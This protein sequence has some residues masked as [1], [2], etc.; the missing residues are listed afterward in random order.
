MAVLL[1]NVPLIMT[2]FNGVVIEEIQEAFR[3]LGY[4]TIAEIMTASDFGVP[5]FRKRAVVIGYRKD[6]GFSPKMPS[7]THE[8]IDYAARLP[9]G[10]KRKAQGGLLPYITVEDA[11]ATCRD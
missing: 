10:K 7:A 3:E 11:S 2:A 1:E 9:H 8:T 5:Q 4:Q 6:L